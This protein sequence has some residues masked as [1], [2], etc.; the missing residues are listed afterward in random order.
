MRTKKTIVSCLSLAALLAT[1]VAMA[2][3]RPSRD[4]GDSLYREQLERERT[5]ALERSPEVVPL[6]PV[7]PAT[8]QPEDVGETGPVFPIHAIHLAGDDLLG[9]QR[10]ARLVAPFL[11]K[12]LGIHRINLLIDRFNRELVESGYITSR[13]Y[14]G[15]QNLT[16]GALTVTVVA[17]RI[18]AIQYN[19]T[20]VGKQTWDAVGFRL[21]APM[22]A[23]EVLYLPDIEQ[24]VD[25][26]N[27]SRRNHVQVSIAPGS[28]AGGSIV[29]FVNRQDAA[30]AYQVAADNQGSEG[31]GTLRLHA[32]IDAGDLLGWM[33]NLSVAVTTSQETNALN[34]TLTVPLGYW[35]LSLMGA[36]SEYQ[37]LIG[38]TALVYGTS[39][40]ASLA[41]N[42]ILHRDADSKTALDFLL[43]RRQSER[44]V[45]NAQLTPQ[46][47]GVARL[48]IN[49]LARF[50]SAHGIGQWTLD[51]GVNLGLDAFG[52]T[53]DPVGLPD[54]AAR[55]QF[56]KLDFGASVD[57]PLSDRWTWRGRFVGQWTED[58]LYSSEQLFAG[59]VGSVRGF[60][61]SAQ[62]GDRGFYLRNEFATWR[63]TRLLG[64]S[65]RLEPFIFLD[66]GQ[67]RTL[68][69]GRDLTL[70]GAGAGM[71]IGFRSG[72]A[73]LILGRPLQEPDGL[74]DTGT[75][76]NA[77]IA[78]RF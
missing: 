29:A 30:F 18:E 10:F 27:R 14:V 36:W 38:D 33:E 74:E 48:G 62:G 75:R 72:H 69:D 45:N 21:A 32:S 4:P 61:E 66:A 57:V 54:E 64:E 42:R 47:I 2:S 76:L 28:Q 73:E 43:T 65:L 16:E 31:T 77:S 17:G 40:S 7:P 37:N 49:H 39:E 50:E 8:M 59:G 53:R 26:L 11:G 56:R 23:G 71:R 25:Q 55:A 70:V 1:P 3:D 20:H 78:Y 35:T 44:S 24:T 9:A 6:P 46:V 19:G 51:A 52:A 13:A 60:P 22:V 63:Q 41:C 15:P 5:R 12:G 58:A 67:L 68:A 34:A